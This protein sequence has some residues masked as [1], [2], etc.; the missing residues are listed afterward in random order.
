MK[1]FLTLATTAALVLGSTNA[2]A[3]SSTF[4]DINT[5]PWPGAATFIDEAASLGLMSGYTENGKKYCKPRNKVTYCEATQLMYS[6]MKTYYKQDVTNETITKW[7][8]IMDAYKI[9]SWAYN[10]VA[11]ALDKGILVTNDLTKF[12]KGNT[13]QNANREDVG[14]IFGKALGKVYTV[15]MDAK[16]TFKDAGSISKASVPYLDL[17]YDK[18][19]M[20]GD[21]YN[22]FNPKVNI[23][24]SEMAVLSVKTYKLLTG[25]GSTGSTGGTTTK[26]E[27]PSNGSV[28]GTIVNVSV[29]ENGDLFCSVKTNTGTGLNLF[30]KKGTAKA[31]YDGKEIDFSEIGTGDSV[32][33]SYANGDIKTIT[34]T[35]SVNG[36]GSKQTFDL[37]DMTSNKITVKDGSKEKT[38]TMADDVKV[39]LDDKSTTPSRIYSALDNGDDFSVTIYLNADDKVTKLYAT[40]KNDNPKSGLLTDLD[41]DELTIKVNGKSYDYDVDSDVDVKDEL[42]DYSFSDLK[43]HYDDTDFYVTLTTNSKNAVTKITVNYAEDEVNGV[44]TDVTSR[45][46]TIK[47]QGDT[48][49]YNLDSDVDVKVDGKSKDIDF[50]KEN[51]EKTSYRVSLTL[52]RD[53][54]VTDIVAIEESMG[55]SKGIIKRLSSSTIEIKNDKGDTFSYDL[56]DDT[57]DIDVTL[58]G[59]S[60]DFD[61]LKDKYKEYD[62]RAELSFKNKQVSKIVAVNTEADEG[63][64]RAIDEDEITILVDGDKFTYDLDDDVEVTLEDD[65][66][67]LSKLIKDFED[68]ENF[69]VK[70]KFNSSK[71]KVTE[72]EAEY[73]SSKR[74]VKGDLD[75]ISSSYIKVDGKKYYLSKDFDKDDDVYGDAK[76]Y[77]DLDDK[78]DDGDGTDFIIKLK[79]NSSGEVTRIDAEKD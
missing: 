40:T 36:I 1:R 12:M 46:L 15:D 66:Y 28:T 55:E 4:A 49:T 27:T 45:K 79:L 13:Q 16:L 54:D 20:V 14:V 63:E 24:R 59:K 41:D 72:I 23:N 26:P 32:S 30:G 18:N 64:L 61:D 2:V 7:K 50:L 67:T 31:Y 51:H 56:L 25:S 8:P 37:V 76:D 48:Y 47:A 29:L 65:D 70:L 58:N 60:A 42:T 73:S 68:Y 35:K 11:Y 62:I 34:V 17:L 21:D 19:I 22:N 57:D 5:V 39:Y 44:L 77:D 53:D 69:D 9:P 3:F 52:N 6:I 75:G 74:E 33:L 38:Y 78:Y 43:K 71:S 10:A